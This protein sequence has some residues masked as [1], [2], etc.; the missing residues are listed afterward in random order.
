MIVPTPCFLCTT[1][2]PSGSRRSA[3]TCT[4]F[5]WRTAKRSN[6]SHLRRAAKVAKQQP[7]G[8]RG[9]GHHH[10]EEVEVNFS[11]RWTRCSGSWYTSDDAAASTL[12]W[13]MK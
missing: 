3:G 2:A 7:D 5:E 8:D 1:R 9:E 6:E 4:C 13:I 12:A 10:E 11:N